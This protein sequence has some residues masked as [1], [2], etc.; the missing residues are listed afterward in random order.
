M[1]PSGR[2]ILESRGQQLGNA[3]VELLGED[4]ICMHRQPDILPIAPDM[5]SQPDGHRWGARPATLSQALV[6]HHKVGPAGAFEQEITVL[7]NALFNSTL[8][9]SE[10]ECPQDRGNLT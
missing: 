6:R 10:C 7:H 1:C 3:F 9:G 8:C 4:G 5:V 2:L